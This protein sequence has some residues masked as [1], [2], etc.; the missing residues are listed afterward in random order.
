MIR[1]KEGVILTQEE[2]RLLARKAVKKYDEGAREAVG[3]G[4]GTMLGTIAFAA[5]VMEMEKVIF[6]GEDNEYQGSV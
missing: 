3:E 6:E 4:L 5:G 2:Y 1:T